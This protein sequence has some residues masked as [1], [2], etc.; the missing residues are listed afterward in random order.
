MDQIPLTAPGV[1]LS[2]WQEAGVLEVSRI[3]GAGATEFY[4]CVRPDAGGD[5]KAQVRQVYQRFGRLICD[6]GVGR[7][8]VVSERMYLKDMQQVEV[9]QGV[10]AEFYDKSAGPAT[11]Y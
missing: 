10:R 1:Q 7:S 5:I 3:E 6:Q 11:T 8:A 4:V 2:R 9:L